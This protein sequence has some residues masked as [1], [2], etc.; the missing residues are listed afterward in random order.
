[1]RVDC[2][3]K[4]EK[5]REDLTLGFVGG[6]GRQSLERVHSVGPLVEQAESGITGQHQASRA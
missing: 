5:K 4:R 3:A 1:M 6:L 2:Y